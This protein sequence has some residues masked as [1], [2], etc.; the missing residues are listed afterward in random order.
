[1]EQACGSNELLEPS[2]R[3]DAHEGAIDNFEQILFS[4]ATFLRHYKK[5]RHILLEYFHLTL[6]I[7]IALYFI[8]LCIMCQY[9]DSPFFSNFSVQQG[10]SID[11]AIVTM[12]GWDD[13][14]R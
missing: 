7:C 10:E 5:V 6:T 12:L 1:M 3:H 11:R 9:T 8:L 13:P 14:S 2:L 4:D